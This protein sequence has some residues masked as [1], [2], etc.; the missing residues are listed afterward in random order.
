MLEWNTKATRRLK[1]RTIQLSK[2]ALLLLWMFV[3]TPGSAVIT[4]SAGDVEGANFTFDLQPDDITFDYTIAPVSSSSVFYGPNSVAWAN[5]WTTGQD[6]ANVRGFDPSAAAGGN[7]STQVNS[8]LAPFVSGFS[9]GAHLRAQWSV[10]NVSG[11]A[12][13]LA[14]SSYVYEI[15]DAYYY[16]DHFG[17]PPG[18][19]GFASAY[20]H[21]SVYDSLGF[22][23]LH[24]EQTARM[25]EGEP[26]KWTASGHWDSSGNGSIQTDFNPNLN[27]VTTYVRAN[28]SITLLP[29]Q[30]DTF[31]I[32][33]GGPATAQAVPESAPT[34]GILGL[35]TLLVARR[36]R[37]M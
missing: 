22:L 10:T 26:F 3:E 23:Q 30:S 16:H 32:D 6:S 29:G 19:S 36:F 9:A 33:L 25:G 35:V 24:V 18:W 31:S 1:G 34:I 11:F 13:T 20:G 8:N 17:E 5:A 4:M 37:V 14:F 15:T 21:S 12:Q 27:E 28:G 7:C 2:A